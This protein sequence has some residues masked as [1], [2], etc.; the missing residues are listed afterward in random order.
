MAAGSSPEQIGPSLPSN[1]P[2]IEGFAQVRREFGAHGVRQL[3]GLM[4][5]IN[6]AKRNGHPHGLPMAH[7]Y[8]GHEMHRLGW[9]SRYGPS[10][11]IGMA[12]RMGLLVIREVEGYDYL[13]T[14]EQ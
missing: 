3:L 1:L 6:G 12:V 9:V 8:D 14:M 5:R 13:D 4:E 7:S 11:L 2:Y 10:G